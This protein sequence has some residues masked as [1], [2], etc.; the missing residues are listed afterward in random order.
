MRSLV[1]NNE[2]GGGKYSGFVVIFKCFGA[3][4]VDIEWINEVIGQI[5][6]SEEEHEQICS[7]QLKMAS[8]I[9]DEHFR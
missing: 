4:V 1:L 5:A 8:L 2:S 6:K 3:L 7:I 9:N